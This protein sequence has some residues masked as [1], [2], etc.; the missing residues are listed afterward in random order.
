MPKI[1]LAVGGA[2]TIECLLR[3]IGIAD[4]EFTDPTGTAA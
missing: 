3:R 1:A 2:D 4:A